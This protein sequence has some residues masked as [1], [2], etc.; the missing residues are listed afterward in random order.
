MEVTKAVFVPEPS[1]VGARS[2][3][4]RRAEIHGL[5]PIPLGLA[6]AARAVRPLYLARRPGRFPSPA[7]RGASHL[8]NRGLWAFEGECGQTV[9]RSFWSPGEHHA[10]SAV[11][12]S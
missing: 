6:G 3:L 4:A 1:G 11:A 2:C 10:S 7:A 8:C 9:A 12:P 5:R